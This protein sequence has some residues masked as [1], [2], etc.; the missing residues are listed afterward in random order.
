MPSKHKTNPIGVRLP[1]GEE[2]AVRA[3]AEREGLS[4]RQWLLAAIREKLARKPERETGWCANCHR[5]VYLDDPSHG[6]GCTDSH[7]PGC[8]CGRQPN[9]YD[10]SAQRA[11]QEPS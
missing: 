2:R 9:I 6:N 5:T 3:A 10:G 7:D 11:G 8:G 1:E 4:L